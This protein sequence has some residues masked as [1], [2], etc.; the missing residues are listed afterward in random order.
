M[1]AR[2]VAALAE[3]TGHSLEDWVALVVAEGPEGEKERVAWLKT[4]HGL[5]TNY[6]G[7]FAE[8]AD[9]RGRERWDVEAYLAAA[10]GYIE[11]QYAGKKE[12]LRP[13]FDRLLELGISLGGDVAVCPAK[14]MVPFYRKHVFAQI[15]ASTQSRVDLGLALGEVPA[16]RR[17]ID[18]G[19]AAKGD[20]ITHR[21]PVSE[22]TAIDDELEDLWRQAYERDC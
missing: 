22:L 13:I 2:M 17:L 1:G 5:G 9:G 21:V 16:E 15:K 10:P 6:A 20:R 14:T 4:E 8:A 12:R 3:K 11:A 7:V 19:G 18:T